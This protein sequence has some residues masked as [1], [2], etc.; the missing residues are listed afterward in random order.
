M[1][2]LY[3]LNLSVNYDTPK[4]QNNSQYFQ[5]TEMNIKT[6]IMQINYSVDTRNDHIK[7]IFTN[8]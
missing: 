3:G 4:I 5:G 8:I 2:A 7:A 1:V 6:V